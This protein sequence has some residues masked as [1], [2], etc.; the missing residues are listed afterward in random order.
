MEIRVCEGKELNVMYILSNK[1]VKNKNKESDVWLIDVY[2]NYFIIWKFLMNLRIIF[3][4]LCFYLN[5]VC[6][7]SEINEVKVGRFGVK[8]WDM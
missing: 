8:W 1:W 4:W 5:N 6:I 3:L 2:I 7:I